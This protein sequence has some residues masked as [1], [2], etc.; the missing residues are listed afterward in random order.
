M[1]M[2]YFCKIEFKYRYA[3]LTFD[4]SQ[5]NYFVNDYIYTDLTKE[6]LM[7]KKHIQNLIVDVLHDIK[8]S[9]HKSVIWC[10]VKPHLE[11]VT[12]IHQNE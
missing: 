12:I 8:P 4:W 11:N 5:D 6:Q 7:D 1:N 9:F 3:D 2:T 10:N